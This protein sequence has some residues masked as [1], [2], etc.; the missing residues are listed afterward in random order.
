VLFYKLN[1]LHFIEDY[2]G[3]RA[4]LHYIRDKDGREVDF[5]IVINNKVIDLIEVKTTDSD[6]SS[7]LKYYAKN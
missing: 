7:A 5:A 3:E 4:S 6:V 2:F 1:R